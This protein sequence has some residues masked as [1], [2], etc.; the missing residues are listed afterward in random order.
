MAN[1]EQTPDE[2][3]SKGGSRPDPEQSIAQ[4]AKSA[5][6]PVARGLSQVL[7]QGAFE[8]FGH[9]FTDTGD[10]ARDTANE[11]SR[12]A[13][14]RAQGAKT[15]GAL[16]LR[17][18][19]M[20]YENFQASSVEP[21]IAAKK[22]MLERYKQLHADLDTGLWQGPPDANG[23]PQ[24]LQ[25]DITKPADREQLIRLR[26]QIEKDFYGKNSDMDVELF[27]LAHK[28]P[29]NP[30]IN[31]RI[32]MIATA[33]SDQLMK[34]T[35]PDQSL[36]AEKG[37]ADITATMMNEDSKKLNAQAAVKNAGAKAL[38]EPTGLRQVRNHPEIGPAGAMEWLIGSD[39]GQAYTYGNRGGDSMRDAT[40]HYEAA[41]IK[42]T[43]SLKDD[44]EALGR[45]MAQ[46]QGRIRQL[47]AATILHDQAPDM[48]VESR[49][50]TPWFFEF[51]KSGTKVD[52]ILN[53]T[54]ERGY[55]G[56]RRMSTE[57]KK[58]LFEGWK[59]QWQKELDRWAS[60]PENELTHDNAMDH[61]ETWIKDAISNG[62]DGVPHEL[63]IAMNANTKDL[64]EEL[65]T[66]LLSHGSR[67]MLDNHYMAEASPIRNIL[68]KA[69]KPFTSDKRRSGRRYR[70]LRPGRN[71]GI[72]GE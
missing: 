50:A 46:M 69:V 5:V 22:E 23:V 53:D 35:N 60:K 18:H 42:K 21:Y 1:T 55:K 59:L 58:D 20:E 67:T 45:A 19:T 34:A 26:G 28:Y 13:P 7:M 15:A 33:Y 38:K 47:A 27:N 51:E 25:L 41:L 70:G 8:S 52:G 11:G 54:N 36:A 64:R 3:F 4:K 24:T 68:E 66:A 32:Q 39:A 10:V 29:G 56:D 48:E 31:K 9:A 49:K 71:K 14:W 6:G 37:A 72:L 57:R 40:N 16:E 65:V 61:M 17:W 63:T 2:V 43:P 30:L 12:M 44:P 62:A